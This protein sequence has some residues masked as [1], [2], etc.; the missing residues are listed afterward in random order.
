MCKDSA[1]TT[2]TPFLSPT[3]E[4]RRGQ[5]FPTLTP[6]EVNAARRFAEP[7][8]FGDGERVFER[9]KQAAGLFV[10]LSGSI[11]M[12]GRDAHGR[13]LPVVEHMERQFAGELGQLTGARAYVDG[14]A[15]G[16]VQTLLLAPE[17]LRK[18]LIAEAALGEKLVRALTLRRVGLIESGAGGP[19]LI[20]GKRS[21]GI[22]RLRNFLRRNGIPHSALDPADDADA[23]SIADHYAQEDLPLAV[24]PDGSVL[25]NPG[26]TEIARCIGMLDGARAYRELLRISD[27]H[28]WTGADGTRVHPGA[29]VRRPHDDSRRSP[30]LRERRCGSLRPGAERQPDRSFTQRGGRDR[31]ALS[32]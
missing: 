4:S 19:L 32:P 17:Q 18:L 25:R 2:A 24:C 26:E 29:E 27:G 12:T 6:E 30:A 28:L 21:P 31:C 16:D 20:G 14:T 1:M 13:D 5:M 23:R 7:R 3:L 9:G 8:R 10:V 22:L 11:R 15:V